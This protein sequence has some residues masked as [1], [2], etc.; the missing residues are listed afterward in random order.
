MLEILKA[1]GRW[2]G[3]TPLSHDVR[4]ILTSVV[5]AAPTVQ[6]IH[7]LSVAIVIGSAG[8]ICLKLLGF[9]TQPLAALTKKFIP[10]IWCALV[11]LLL[12]GS[13]L[14]LNR[15]MRYFGNWSFLSKITLIAIGMGVIVAIQQ[16]VRR[17]PQFGD[18]ATASSKALGAGL[19]VLWL[20]VIFAGRWIAYV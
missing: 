16:A 12:S 20:A 15:P 10:P 7:I 6:T 11:V 14:I 5:W 3:T 8:A 9:S 1:F 13:L 17:D 19:A 18:T 2:L 4:A